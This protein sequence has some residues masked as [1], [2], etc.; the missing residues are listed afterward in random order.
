[1][2]STLDR[3]TTFTGQDTPVVSL[4]APTTRRPSWIVAGVILVGLAALLGAYVFSAATDTLRVTVA[5]EDL[6]PGDV[7]GLGDLRVVELGRTGELRAILAD[8][9]S[10]VI[11]LTPQ[12]PIPAG[13][14][15][16][17]G[18]FIGPDEAIPP[19]KVVVGASFGPGEV[20]TPTLAINDRVDALVVQPSQAGAGP[21]G[22]D[23]PNEAVVIGDAT[24]WAVTGDASTGSSSDRVWV[25]LLVDAD[26][27][28][29]VVQAAADER[30]RLSLVP[31]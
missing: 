8:Q 19:G 1:M 27:Q 15:L 29:R 6:N 18:L 4:S 22:V 5:A 9:Q 16:N 14:L 3:S 11:G 13:T 7:I 26:L 25:S 17:T 31:R 10:L 28:T 20:P 30:L 2:T 21:S 23:T 12:A 24:I